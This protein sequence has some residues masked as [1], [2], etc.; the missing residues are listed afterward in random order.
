MCIRD[1]YWR[2]DGKPIWNDVNL[3]A[4]EAGEAVAT[5]K[6]AEKLTDAI[7]QN[8]GIDPECINAAYED[9][10]HWLVKEGNLPDL[11]LIHI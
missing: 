6:Q 9:P 7:C 1:S 8:L 3:I 4:S 2:K 10:G 11:S 5:L